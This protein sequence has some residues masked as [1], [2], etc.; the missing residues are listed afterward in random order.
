[1]EAL[2]ERGLDGHAYVRF[3]LGPRLTDLISA[4][5]SFPLIQP[6]I[7]SHAKTNGLPYL[8]D[9][10]MPAQHDFP[11]EVEPWN[12]AFRDYSKSA[13]ID[14]ALETLDL[15]HNLIDSMQ[16]WRIRVGAWIQIATLEELISWTCP[17]GAELDG[18]ED[19]RSASQSDLENHYQ[20]ISDRL[21]ETYLH[22]WE[23]QSLLCEYRWLH[24]LEQGT[25]PD[26]L[27]ELRLLPLAIVNEEI[28]RRVAMRTVDEEEES[29]V[30]LLEF[31]ATR[32]LTVGDYLSSASMWKVCCGLA[33][34][35]PK[36]W[37]NLGFSLI[38]TDPRKALR[39][40]RTAARMGYS[41][42]VINAC[43]RMLCN[44]L[45]ENPREVLSIA[46]STWP[47]VGFVGPVAAILWSRGEHGW[48]LASLPDARLELIHLAIEAARAVGDGSGSVW[49]ERLEQ[50]RALPA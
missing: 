28:A 4:L 49:L 13:G 10:D 29:T 32:M 41:E 34:N 11:E 25:F 8:L 47:K 30:K 24:G 7:V 48:T 9:E 5:A 50:V 36:M 46:D 45:L 15:L 27:M 12:R 38:P 2:T 35:D 44:Q 6:L 22:G 21:G 19:F 26:S 1:M 33:P 17:G 14:E 23:M 31:Q 18:A 40:L 16:E 43:N 37:N 39:H 42:P 3:A 20:W